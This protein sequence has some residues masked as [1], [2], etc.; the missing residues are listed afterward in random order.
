[1]PTPDYKTRYDHASSSMITTTPSVE[2][3]KSDIAFKIAN[4]FDGKARAALI[5][6]GWHPPIDTSDDAAVW[7]LAEDRTPIDVI[8]C[9]ARWKLDTI[10]PMMWRAAFV[11]GWRAAMIFKKQ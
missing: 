1:M 9:A 6:L 7:Q 4:D 11:A 5:S 10:I 2:K 8:E 3:V